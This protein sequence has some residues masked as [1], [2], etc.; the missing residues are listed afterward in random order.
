[1]ARFTTRV[2]LNGEPSRRNYEALH[3]AMKKKGFLQIITGRDGMEYQLPHAEY[4]CES[5]LP[6]QQVRDAA[7]E[8]AKSVWPDVDILVT[9]S[10]A[11]SWYLR[12]V[13]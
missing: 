10:A 2:Q 6:I 11:R 8:A 3:F 13:K 1:M 9:Q 12:K 4:N 7:R 5:D